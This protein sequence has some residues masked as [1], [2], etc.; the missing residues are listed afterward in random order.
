M[1]APIFDSHAHYTSR[2]FDGDRYELL[3]IDNH[4]APITAA[5]AVADVNPFTFEED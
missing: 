1:N 5:D 4:D 3:D 2:Q